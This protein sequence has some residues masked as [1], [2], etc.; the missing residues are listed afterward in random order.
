MFSTRQ[1]LLS[2]AILLAAFA[3]CKKDATGP[4]SI[5][6]PGT[7][8]ANLNG[9]DSTFSTPPFQSFL[10]F[11]GLSSGGGGPT[12]PFAGIRQ[13]VR[14]TAPRAPNRQ[15]AAA[16]ALAM[17][18]LGPM[19]LQGTQAI[20]PDSLKGKTFIYDSASAQYVISDSTGAPATGV[21]FI[22]YAVDPGGNIVFP[23]TPVGHL[24]LID[25]STVDAVVLEV[26]VAGPTMTYVDYTTSGSG[27]RSAFTLTTAGYIQS[28]VRRLDFSVSYALAAGSFTIAEHFDDTADDV[29]LL[30]NF[31]I[32]ATSDTSANVSATF[33]FSH[34]GQSIALTGA[35]TLTTNTSAL[36]A[37]V[38]VNGAV[39]ALITSV[40]DTTTITDKNGNPLSVA[41]RLALARMFDILGHALDWLNDLVAPFV[42]LTPI[43]V[44]LQL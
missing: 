1:R 31:G 4:A 6:D 17:R 23:L 13:L 38:K 12:A 37:T 25:E 15:D 3:A 10:G 40:N 27:T 35:G 22:L 30:F 7:V 34:A 19:I 32:V 24:D 5:T 14:A 20:F 26:I 29:H 43:G 36:Q 41:D 33:T 18:T 28:S 39:F 8:T 16:R 21:R 9:V 2:A 11:W 44:Y 42:N